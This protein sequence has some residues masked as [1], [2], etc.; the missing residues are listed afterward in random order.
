MRNNRCGFITAYCNM[1]GRKSYLQGKGRVLYIF[2]NKI[3]TDYSTILNKILP[4]SFQEIK[5]I[6]FTLCDSMQ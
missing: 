6:K 1:D 3:F 2:S 4:I 5:T